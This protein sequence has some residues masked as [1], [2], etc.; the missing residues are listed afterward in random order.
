MHFS[1]NFLKAFRTAPN[2]TPRS[3]LKNVQM[4]YNTVSGE[5]LSKQRPRTATIRTKVSSLQPRR[6]TPNIT[7]YGTDIKRAYCK[8]SELLPKD[9]HIHNGVYITEMIVKIAPECV[10]NIMSSTCIYV[11]SIVENKKIKVGNDQE[12]TQ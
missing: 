11:L 9:S 4:I 2:G 5:S 1:T 8:S 3:V 12:M 7:E 10:H 6:K